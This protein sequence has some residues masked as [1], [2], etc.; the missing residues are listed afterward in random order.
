SG[1]PPEV[2]AATTTRRCTDNRLRRPSTVRRRPKTVLALTLAGRSPERGACF[3]LVPAARRELEV[4]SVGGAAFRRTP[5][6]QLGA[7]DQNVG[8]GGVRIEGERA[9]G[10]LRGGG[11]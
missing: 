4:A 1:I 5:A 7:R 3:G 8:L 9:L 2:V 10:P 6:L 11:D